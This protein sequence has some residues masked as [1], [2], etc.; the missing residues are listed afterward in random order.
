MARRRSPGR[1]SPPRGYTDA[2]SSEPEAAG[3]EGFL[4]R[5]AQMYRDDER[6]SLPRKGKNG[7]N[8]Q[9]RTKPHRA[10]SAHPRRL[11]TWPQHHLAPAG[12][13]C[14]TPG[15]TSCTSLFGGEFQVHPQPPGRT[16][17][18]KYTRV[19]KLLQ[20][21]QWASPVP[22]PLEYG[23]ADCPTDAS[24]PPSICPSSF[25]FSQQDKPPLKLGAKELKRGNWQEPCES[26]PSIGD[27]MH[28][29]A[30]PYEENEPQG[31]LSRDPNSQHHRQHSR[32][33]QKSRKGDAQINLQDLIDKRYEDLMPE[34]DKKIAALMLARHQDEEEMKDRQLQ[35]SD[36]WEKMRHKERKH[37]VRMEKERHYQQAEYLDQWQRDRDQRKAKLRLE[38]QQLLMAREKEMMLRDKKWKKMAKEQ[39]SRRRMKLDSNKLQ[40]DYKKCQERQLW[41]RRSN[42]RNARDHASHLYKEQM[43]QALERRLIK[44][45]ERKR[46]RADTNQYKKARHMHTK[47]QVDDRVKAEELYKRLCIEQKLQRSQEILEQLI[48]ERNR[49]LKERSFKEEDQDV[50]TKVRAKETEEEK[51]R[52]KEMLLQIAEMKIQQ[53]KEMMTKNIQGRAQRARDINWMKERNHDCRK[54]KLD[55]DEK[56]HLREI[57]EAIRRK[58]QKSNQILR[59]KETAIE[60]SRRIAKASYD[61]KEK[62]RD[63]IKHGSVDQMA[64]DAHR[65]ANLLRGL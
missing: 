37:K 50:I 3:G 1:F 44:E 9:Q 13:G 24:K 18:G 2:Y 23:A 35:V 12:E 30:R 4:G 28:S 63:L 46:K 62:V 11:A 58:D 59:D 16:P 56:C 29:L 27:L 41:D 8:A 38:E 42:E 10:A 22:R 52:R 51:R 26:S 31:Y 45:M 64:F 57:K 49:E 53:A 34:R 36:V 43:L 14:A 40:A 17:T 33:H 19:E 54:Q 39:E 21:D 15:T 65:N 5:L 6:T 20:D 25:S 55:D 47:E 48:E 61:L 60:E 32:Y 7:S